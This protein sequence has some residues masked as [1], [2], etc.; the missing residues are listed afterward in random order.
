MG[1]GDATASAI[2]TAVAS[3]LS[4]I[5]DEK[6]D[7]MVE[8]L[9]K[10]GENLLTL[11]DYPGLVKLSETVGQKLSAALRSPESIPAIDNAVKNLTDWLTETMSKESPAID[12][13]VNTAMKG[14]D[15]MLQKSSLPALDNALKTAT[16]KLAEI[17]QKEELPAL[18]NA[19]DT[20][21]KKLSS[22]DDSPLLV[23]LRYNTV[24]GLLVVAALATFVM[25]ITGIVL[26]ARKKSITSYA[27]A[28][29]SIFVIGCAIPAMV[30]GHTIVAGLFA[31]VGVALAVGALVSGVIQGR[32]TSVRG[33][34]NKWLAGDKSRR[35]D[36]VITRTTQ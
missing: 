14:L 22:V 11:P 13:A 19:I 21:V 16:D 30:T 10:S 33:I 1:F 2:G 15:A 8:K 18:N 27:L 17:L 20:F 25:A 23:K 12:S 34:V 5:I 9:T 26:G 29:A 24:V 32:G 7:A 4:G 6:G 36:M 35:S 28:G 3:A 31:A